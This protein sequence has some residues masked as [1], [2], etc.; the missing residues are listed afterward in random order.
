MRNV[1]Q[2][3]L[4]QADRITRHFEKYLYGQCAYPEWIRLDIPHSLLRRSKFAQLFC[5]PHTK[6]PHACTIGIR[7]YRTGD[8]LKR[9]R[10]HSWR[11]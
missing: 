9:S 11:P 5:H 2:Y 10:G 1:T 3:V 6:A 7:G 8:I 4:F